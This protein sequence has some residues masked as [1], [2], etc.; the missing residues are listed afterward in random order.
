M[1][2]LIVSEPPVRVV[3]TGVY[4]GRMMLPLGRLMARRALE[5]VPDVTYKPVGDDRSP[6]LPLYERALGVARTVRLHVRRRSLATQ[7]PRVALE[8]FAELDPK[9]FFLHLVGPHE[10]RRGELP[11]ELMTFHGNLS[12]AQLRDL[13]RRVHV[14]LSPVSVKVSG[15][16]G[17]FQGVTDGF[18]PRRRPTR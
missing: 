16:P 14:F 12:P 17:T 5:N 4:R 3:E 7:G 10:H 15:R 8:A 2:E 11:E 6:F 9:R 18:P 13:H 1:V